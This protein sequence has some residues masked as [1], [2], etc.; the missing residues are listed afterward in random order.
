MT[1][2]GVA[3]EGNFRQFVL[4]TTNDPQECLVRCQVRLMS[5]VCRKEAMERG[6]REHGV[7]ISAC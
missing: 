3:Y 5:C 1:D 6:Q 7:G 2:E 4:A